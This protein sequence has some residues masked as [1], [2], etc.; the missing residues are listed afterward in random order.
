MMPSDVKGLFKG[1]PTLAKALDAAA[2]TR[3]RF[4]ETGPVL[5]QVAPQFA[6]Q[7]LRL[8]AEAVKNASGMME[9]L[10][11]VSPANIKIGEALAVEDR[12][13]ALPAPYE[14]AGPPGPP[15]P[16]VWGS[17]G[18]IEFGILESPTSFGGK[19]AVNYAQHAIIGEKPRLQYTGAKL[20][21]LAI[22]VYWHSSFEEDIEAKLEKLHIA[23]RDRKVLALVVGKSTVGSVY[24]KDWVIADI[25]RSVEK[26]RHDGSI[27]AM[28]ATV[29]LLEWVADPELETTE[30]KGK[31]LTQ[32]PAKKPTPAQQSRAQLNP[33]TGDYEKDGQVIKRRA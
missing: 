23:M 10:A 30:N 1:P 16:Q 7:A 11:I 28:E 27:M 32:P 31:A 12:N 9:V 18:D 26:F 33:K 24:A 3:V 5:L 6:V 20:Q 22:K 19:D 13:R 8:V 25:D 15:S 14:V 21:T 2:M 17:L 4:R 29:N